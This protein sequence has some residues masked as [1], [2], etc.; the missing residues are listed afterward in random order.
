VVIVGAGLSG[1]LLAARLRQRFDVTV[2]ELTAAGRPLMNE[3][4]CAT[5]GINTTINRASGLGGTTA[6]WH[7]ALIE[8]DHD[9]L[10][11]SLLDPT[12]FA[13]WYR[14]AWQFFLNEQQLALADQTHQRHLELAGAAAATVAHMVVPQHRTNMWQRAGQ[15]YPGDPIRVIYGAATR[16]VRDG[17]GG[18]PSLEVTLPDGTL[19]RL[20]ADRFIVAAGGLATP[21]LL[22][23]SFERGEGPIGDYHDHPMAYVAKVRLRPGSDL[24]TISCRDTAALSIRSGFVHQHDGLKAGFYLRPALSMGLR[25]ITGGARYILSDLRNDPF[26]PRKILQLLGN[27]EA[28]REGLL[29]KSRAGFRGDLYSILMLGEQRPRPDRGTRLLGDGRAA[30]DW[31]VDPEEHGAYQAAWQQFLD[32]HQGDIVA[33]RAVPG[34]EWDYRTAAHHSGGAARFQDAGAL[35]AVRDLPG[36][37]VCDASVLRRGG[38]ANSGLTLT[39]LA[40]RL[41]DALEQ[42]RA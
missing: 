7:N 38:I 31:V 29:F 40:L 9:E 39:A 26:S 12:E 25:S 6:Y 28:I 2:V 41:A 10:R 37:L 20:E 4:L 16:F 32:Q 17:A 1:S 27:P 15:V 23:R 5:G 11:G 24:K 30:L 13:P 18:T 33:V 22:A 35:H 14:R 19:Q 21:V 42:G 36:V 3:I 34:A 8:L